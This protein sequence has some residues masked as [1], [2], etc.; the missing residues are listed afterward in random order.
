MGSFMVL[1]GIWLFS[2]AFCFSSLSNCDWGKKFLTEDG[3][4]SKAA[5]VALFLV[6]PAVFGSSVWGAASKW[7][8][9]QKIEASIEVKVTEAAE[10]E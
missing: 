8:K 4:W 6:A 2:F 10:E 1:L 7:L 3:K 9:E 5:L